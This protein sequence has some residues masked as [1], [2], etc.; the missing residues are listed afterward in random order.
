MPPDDGMEVHRGLRL[1]RSQLK[2]LTDILRKGID[3]E[4]VE[5][6]GGAIATRGFFFFFLHQFCRIEVCKEV[7]QDW[8]DRLQRAEVILIKFNPNLM[9]LQQLILS[10]VR[11]NLHES[12]CGNVNN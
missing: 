8:T 9:G 4:K 11:R 3:W 10:H 2:V 5:A 7:F 6:S 12:A 1:Q